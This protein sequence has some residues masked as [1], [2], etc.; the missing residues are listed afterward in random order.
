[1]SFTLLLGGV[2]SG[3]SRLAVELGLRAEAPVVFVAT[4]EA[5][6]DDMTRRIAAHRE[7]RP[8]AWRTVEAP[9]QLGDAVAALGPE[10]FVIVDCLTVWTANLLLD[11]L[12]DHDVIARAEALADHLAARPGGGVVV[13]NEVGMGVHPSSE[14]G[15][16]YRDLLGAVN[17]RVGARARRAAL[18]VAGRALPLVPAQGL[19]A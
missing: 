1:M 5:G 14:L 19:L 7:E 4:A 12:A 10:P 8:A 15:R 18:V 13:T 3:K 11:G 16:H 9:R 17:V 2:R 6:D